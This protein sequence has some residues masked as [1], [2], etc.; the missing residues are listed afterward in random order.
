MKKG[1]SITTLILPILLICCSKSS[2][3]A[4]PNNSALIGKWILVGALADPGD[5]SGKWIPVNNSNSYLQFNADNSIKSNTYSEFG[6]LIKYETKND[7]LVSFIYANGNIVSLFY[8]INKDSLTLS[9]GC[10][11][12]CGSKFIRQTS[13]Y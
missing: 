10:I 11:E 7:S 12:A 9:G 6:G 13:Q 1:L 2:E 8:E 3:T 4:N 5:G